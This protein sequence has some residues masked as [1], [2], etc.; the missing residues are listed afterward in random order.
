MEADGLGIAFRRTP[1][2][3]DASG[4][5][6]A[7]FV[8]A[9]IWQ[10]GAMS[11]EVL[12]GLWQ[13]GVWMRKP[14]SELPEQLDPIER[15]EELGLPDHVDLDADV[16][17]RALAVALYA[18]SRA[19]QFVLNLP[20]ERAVPIAAAVAGALPAKFGLLSF[21]SWE[22]PERAG[23]Y[24]L[25]GE[26]ANSR[27]ADEPV[28]DRWMLAARLLFAGGNGTD[29]GVVAALTERATD[30]R[31]F[32]RA[33]G[34]WADI[35]RTCLSAEVLDEASMAFVSMDPRFVARLA[36]LGGGADGLARAVAGGAA[37]DAFFP[38]ARN[39]RALDD[40]LAAVGAQLGRLRPAEALGVVRRLDGLVADTGRMA[41]TLAASWLGGSLADLRA[42]DALYLATLL[43]GA[44]QSAITLAAV[45]EI[46]GNP[47][48]TEPLVAS[49]LPVDWRA[50]AAAGHPTSVLPETLVQG[51]ADDRRF[52]PVYLGESGAEGLAALRRALR[53]APRDQA[54]RA[55]EHAAPHL[56]TPERL[57]LL[58]LVV[59]RL[60]ARERL[61]ALERWA[62]RDIA[63]TETWIKAVLDA[64]V[65][66]V[67]DTRE[68]AIALPALG[69]RALDLDV[70]WA[71]A[72]NDAWLQ[73]A[74]V[75]DVRA[76]R[77]RLSS[78]SVE[79]ATRVIARLA[80]A[81]DRDAAT[82]LLIDLCADYAAR[83]RAG[84]F[85]AVQV[86]QAKLGE[87]GD[88]F[89]Q[90]LARAALRRG[91]ID[92]SHVAVWTIRWLALALDAEHLSSDTLRTPPIAA[93]HESLSGISVERVRS[94][95]S[96]DV[97]GKPG[98]RWLQSV[99]KAA[100]KRRKA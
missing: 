77:H 3:V 79:S 83:D 45:D 44:P 34:A 40:V 87:P 25:L 38:V 26:A 67:L 23:G 74:R 5:A 71:S 24:E 73:L 4:R 29:A 70:R 27:C 96:E 76:T 99:A 89:A 7:F 10:P 88:A 93:L 58:W 47:R 82:E 43:S 100:D 28:P 57:E 46:A 63:D 62:T 97:F 59:G 85:R 21:S 68:S 31:Q 32:A 30:R 33:L 78:S 52:A 75:L 95:A 50:H 69:G 49:R 81:R 6:G 2:G 20:P 39:A 8:H 84:W 36:G 51:L 91:D 14:P 92:R 55:V 11:P 9:L 80:D 60:E 90:R 13:A 1:T 53:D 17:E 94:A 86:V 61:R 98:R 15:L 12:A 65:A 41:E 54:L 56:R 18:V 22:E 16:V 35:E 37:G 42:A 64:L 19:G 72:R 48:A 66:A